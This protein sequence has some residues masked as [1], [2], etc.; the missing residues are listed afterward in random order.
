MTE[1]I[2]SASKKDEPKGVG[3]WLLFFCFGL[4]VLG[5]VRTMESLNKT[6]D[7]LHSRTVFPVVRE[8]AFIATTVVLLMTLYGM[9]VGVLIWKGSRHGRTLARQYLVIRATLSFLLAALAILWGYYTF[10]VR[11]AKMMGPAVAS[12]TFLEIGV[13]LVW[14]TYFTYSK[15]VRNTYLEG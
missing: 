10:A 1:E 9:I 7:Q 5:P 6:W 3:G 14:W 15:R 12:S 8:L 4:V 2:Q 11:G 13:C